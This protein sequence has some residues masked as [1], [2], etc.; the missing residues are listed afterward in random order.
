[1][2]LITEIKMNENTCHCNDCATWPANILEENILK[3][4]E[5]GLLVTVSATKTE[6]PVSRLENIGAYWAAS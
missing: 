3:I 1:M 4:F 6:E 2:P 5:I